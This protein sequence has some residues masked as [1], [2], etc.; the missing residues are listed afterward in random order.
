MATPTSDF[1]PSKSAA[2]SSHTRTV[3][4]ELA[5]WRVSQRRAPWTN[6]ESL[7]PPESDEESWIVSYMDILTLLLTL[8]VVI[9]AYYSATTVNNSTTSKATTQVANVTTPAPTPQAPATENALTHWLP[10]L[11]PWATNS[12]SSNSNDAISPQVESQSASANAP[13]GIAAQVRDAMSTLKLGDQLDIT[14]VADAVR[15]DLANDVVFALGRAELHNEGKQVLD[16]LIE[17]FSN[18]NYNIDVEGHT[19][20]LP[21]KTAQFPSNWELS[22]MR[23]TQVARYLI[24][25]GI[26]PTRLRAVGYADTKPRQ[27]ND[28]AENRAKNRRVTFVVQIAPA[29]NETP[30][31]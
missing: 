1:Q 13:L 31:Q 17:L 6:N 30:T 19:D 5:N 3:Q 25:Q 15:I 7:A 14:E 8:F 24:S 12:A 29:K 11:Q 26:A 27:E 23:A 4:R 2:L 18:E 21:I 16:Q 9:I 20:N 22:S 28:S 10:F